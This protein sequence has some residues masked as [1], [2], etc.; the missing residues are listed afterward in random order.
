M[1]LFL[2]IIAI[3]LKWDYVLWLIVSLLVWIGIWTK[4]MIY[5]VPTEPVKQYFQGFGYLWIFFIVVWMI[6][7]KKDLN[8]SCR[9]QR[10]APSDVRLDI[11][12]MA[13]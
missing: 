3:N 11:S 7:S 2:S 6:L 12:L 1:W 5:R 9:E 4:L 13:F 10:Y 8:I